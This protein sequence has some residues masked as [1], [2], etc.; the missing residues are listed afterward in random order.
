MSCAYKGGFAIH[1]TR[2]TSPGATAPV[3]LSRA[4]DTQAH[5][6]Y[7]PG[8]LP[9]ANLTALRG[10]FLQALYEIALSLFVAVVCGAVVLL[11]VIT[12]LLVLQR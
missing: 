9:P 7:S 5:T 4:P 3:P 6:N 11:M 10:P 8:F 1:E 2:G 12:A